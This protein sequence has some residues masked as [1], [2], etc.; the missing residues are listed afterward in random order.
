MRSLLLVL[1]IV[2]SPALVACGKKSKKVDPVKAAQDAVCKCFEK[3]A[4]DWLA[5]RKECYPLA[6]R[7]FKEFKSD[8]K[9]RKAFQEGVTGCMPKKKAK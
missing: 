5:Q 6:A 9:K 3:N 4:S 1:V 2:L 8:A 7:F